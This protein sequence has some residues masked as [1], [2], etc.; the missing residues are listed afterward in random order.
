[1]IK[2]S[3]TD[4]CCPACF[5]PLKRL[6]VS[7][8]SAFAADPCRSEKCWKRGMPR[9]SAQARAKATDTARIAFAPMRDLLAVPSRAIIA[10]SNSIWS[11]K[12]RAT[13]APLSSPPIFSTARRQPK[14]SYLFRSPSRNSKASAVPV[15]APEG[16]EAD[17]R[18]PLSR[19]HVTRTVGLPRLSRI[20]RP[21]SRLILG[22]GFNLADKL[23]NQLGNAYWRL[24]HQ[25]QDGVS[26]PGHLCGS[27][28]LQ[29]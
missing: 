11:L 28:I 24:S 8:G 4:T 10:S 7:L 19:S 16:T 1:M 18:T 20:S 9:S 17:A 23:S 14:P 27:Q 25:C 5:P 26:L 15:E 3:C 29:R 21:K 22:I 13:N 12:A 2:T 6:I